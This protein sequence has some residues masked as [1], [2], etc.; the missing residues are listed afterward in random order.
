MLLPEQFGGG[1]RLAFQSPYPVCDKNQEPVTRSLHLPYIL[2]STLVRISHSLGAHILV[3]L[4]EGS[5][6]SPP[7]S[8]RLQRHFPQTG[9][10]EVIVCGRFA[11]R[12][13]S[14]C[15]TSACMKLDSLPRLTLS[16]HFVTRPP[17]PPPGRGL[18]TYGI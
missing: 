16:L 5:I 13:F 6:L 18:S 17:P 3:S 1:V 4:K 14:E 11:T 8:Y 9:C 15:K 7:I 12:Y 2:E 10:A